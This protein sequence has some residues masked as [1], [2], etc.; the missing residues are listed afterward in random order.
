MLRAA[1]R[2][3]IGHPAVKKVLRR[4]RHRVLST[5][6]VE[7]DAKPRRA[8]P[9][10]TRYRTTIYDYTNN[11]TIFVEGRL[12]RRGRLQVSESGLQPR[13]SREERDAAFRILLKDP[14]LGPALRSKRL[15]PYDAMPPLI[16]LE[17]P[18]GRPERT[19]SVGLLP[20]EEGLRHEIV[21][22]NLIRR[23]VIRF[24][25]RAPQYAVAH[26][27]LC[28]LNPA[29]Q[30]TVSHTAGQMSL[31]VTQGN[32][33]L[34]DLIVVRPAAS[35]GADGSGVELRLV[36]YRGKRVL[37]RAHAPILN[38]KYDDDACGPYRDWLD[39][40]D[41]FQAHGLFVAPA[42]NVSLTPATT[43]LDT[44]LDAGNFN[45]VA[46]Y[47][48]GQETVLKS[49]LSAGWYRYVSEWRLHD[50]GTIRPRF[51]VSAVAHSCVCARHHHHVYWRLDF[52]IRTGVN[53]RV[54]EFNPRVHD[55][56]DV[57]HYETMRYRDPSTDRRW[58]VENAATGEGYD[59]IPGPDDGVATVSPDWPFP[60]G[61]VWFLRYHDFENDD[62]DVKIG[63]EA[64]LNAFL[65]GEVIID[66]D[67]VIWYGAH[68]THDVAADHPGTFGHI[69][70]PTLKPV[71]WLTFQLP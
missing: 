63:G 27:E 41:R 62:S 59:I 5:V 53:N 6:L 66:K 38:V 48:Q 31:Q 8:Q 4:T 17:G 18:H 50:D 1:S 42:F 30:D 22:V 25:R 70:G 60:Q 45:G 15:Q 32:S 58:R 51:G 19:L 24:E 37:M 34:W 10:A 52:D 13:P 69:A 43:I 49:E 40:E 29:W 55:H 11:R 26:D 14:H 9:P 7:P 36:H 3:V 39:S 21:G 28:G 71:N 56:G 16:E 2:F 67:V 20:T 54:R 44:G 65:N 33:V 12:D 46:I 64:A 47:K 35:S 23:S 57:M 61:D 68:V